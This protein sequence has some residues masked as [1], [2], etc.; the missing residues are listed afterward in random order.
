MDDFDPVAN[1]GL[2]CRF[3]GEESNYPANNSRSCRKGHLQLGCWV[4]GQD[5]YAI[6]K[7][8][9]AAIREALK[10][11]KKRALFTSQLTVLLKYTTHLLGR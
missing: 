7:H 4:C 9:S 10:K 2:G 3:G 5:H 1:Y 6:Q 8:F 11:I